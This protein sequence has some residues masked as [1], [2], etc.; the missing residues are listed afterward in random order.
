MNALDH[1]HSGFLLLSFKINP[2]RSWK[3]SGAADIAMAV[4]FQMYFSISL[5]NA[6]FTQIPK[7]WES[8][9]AMAKP[10]PRAIGYLSL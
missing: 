2:P 6:R 8:P 3:A 5:G 10:S 1:G 7:Q 4:T 9:N